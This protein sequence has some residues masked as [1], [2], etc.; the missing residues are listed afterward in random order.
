MGN[1]TAISGSTQAQYTYDD[2]GQM[3]TETLGDTTYTYTYDDAGNI[4]TAS[5]GSSSH[6]YTYG[7]AQ[8]KD[9]LTAYDGHAITYDAI[10]NPSPT[11]PISRATW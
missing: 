5:D 1:I 8:W 11:S 6:T 9:L 3:L 2:L 4:L 7:D 10:G